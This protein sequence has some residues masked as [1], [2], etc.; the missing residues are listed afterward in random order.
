MLPPVACEWRHFSSEG[1]DGARTV[2][3]QVLDGRNGEPC[4]DVLRV[5]VTQPGSQVDDVAGQPSTYAFGTLSKAALATLGHLAGL[6][7]E[8]HKNAISRHRGEG[9]RKGKKGE[10]EAEGMTLALD[11]LLPFAVTKSRIGG[12]SQWAPVLAFGDEHPWIVVR[13]VPLEYTRALVL[14]FLG[15]C[16][17]CGDRHTAL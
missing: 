9:K 3:V 12:D 6:A 1:E 5:K 17:V 14:S 8:R 10:A 4:S 15:S 16:V 11:Q 7:E 13:L 2:A